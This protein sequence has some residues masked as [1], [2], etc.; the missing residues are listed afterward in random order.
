MRT[1]FAQLDCAT[2]VW[3]VL[4]EFR[5]QDAAATGQ[6]TLRD[7]LTHC[8]GGASVRRDEDR[9]V[10]RVDQEHRQ[11]LRAPAAGVAG[12]ALPET[13]VQRRLPRAYLLIVLA[14]RQA[15]LPLLRAVFCPVYF[16]N[17]FDGLD[18]RLY[19]IKTAL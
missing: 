15:L 2:P 4:P 3:G 7:L 11:V 18:R 1:P 19:R 8:T 5:L 12:L 10:Q 17:E 9:F 6:A 16:P 13:G 14:V